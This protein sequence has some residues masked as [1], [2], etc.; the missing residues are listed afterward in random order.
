MTGSKLAAPPPP[1][2]GTDSGRRR[3]AGRASRLAAPGPT[4][5]GG[6][7]TTPPRPRPH[8]VVAGSSLTDAALASPE[9]ER[10]VLGAVLLD[11]PSLATAARRLAPADFHLDRHQLRFQAML[12]LDEQAT[13][14]DLRTLQAWL[15]A[16]GQFEQIGGMAY[17]T[18]L[19]LDLPVLS[20]IG[21]YVAIV[22]D[23]ALRRQLVDTA[24]RLRRAA[25]TEPLSE[26]ASATRSELDRLAAAAQPLA[27][28]PPSSTLP[29]RHESSWSR[30]CCASATA[31]S[32]T[33][34]A[35]SE[36]P[37]G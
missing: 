29:G 1:H 19:D 18:A 31:C 37:G 23:R 25:A 11:P 26:I 27:T 35:G 4:T 2:R 3:R 32:S 12:D 6:A 13:P 24:D 30:A 14:I 22:K 9:A 21:T 36:R 16:R 17:L 20:R 33:A 7:M 15:E 5:N 34:G 28:S 10:A 8:L